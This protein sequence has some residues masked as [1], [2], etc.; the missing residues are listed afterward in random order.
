MDNFEQSRKQEIITNLIEGLDWDM[1]RTFYTLQRANK[2]YTTNRRNIEEIKQNLKESVE[3]FIS[4]D[5]DEMITGNFRINR[6]KNFDPF[7]TNGDNFRVSFEICYS[8]SDFN[9]KLFKEALNKNTDNF[10]EFLGN[11]NK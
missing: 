2:T 7:D 11:E 5:S 6:M 8:I 10:L 1:I 9:V 4:N 3:R